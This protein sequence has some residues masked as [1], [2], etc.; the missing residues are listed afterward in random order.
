MKRKFKIKARLNR[1]DPWQEFTGVRKST[2][3]EIESHV[4]NSL[5]GLVYEFGIFRLDAVFVPAWNTHVIRWV[6]KKVVI[7]EKESKGEEAR[8]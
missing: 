8:S 5:A 1:D 7:S 2:L 6:L 4:I 3:E